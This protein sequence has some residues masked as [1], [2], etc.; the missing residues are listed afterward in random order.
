MLR[1]ESEAL[2]DAAGSVATMA[3]PPADLWAELWRA[4]EIS[5]IL[6]TEKVLPAIDISQ[7]TLCVILAFCGTWEMGLLVT[8]SY[9][10]IVG[11]GTIIHS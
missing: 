1:S 8:M 2:G 11:R 3:A 10:R 9:G 5:P 6:S 7:I 4:A